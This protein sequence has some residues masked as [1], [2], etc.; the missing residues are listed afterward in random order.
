[1]GFDVVE[2]SCGDE[3]ITLFQERGPF[4]LVLTD[5]YYFDHVPEPP[6]E[7]TD[8][9]RDGVQFAQSVRM[10]KPDQHIAIHTGSQLQLTG[11]LAAI[12]ILK[13]GGK[14]FLRE[15]E[16]LLNAL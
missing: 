10:M 3:A 14:D 9:I 1:M 4:D 6:L 5:L 13:K 2:S 15:L 8:C 16:A 11:E 12:P 7:K